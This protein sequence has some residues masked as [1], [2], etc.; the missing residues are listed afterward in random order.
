MVKVQTPAVTHGKIPI[1]ARK[2]NTLFS[3]PFVPLENE[4]QD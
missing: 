1:Q 2:P 3:H 4:T